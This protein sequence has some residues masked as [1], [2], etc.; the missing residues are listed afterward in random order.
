MCQI[1][2]FLLQISVIVSKESTQ[3]LGMTL[4]SRFNSEEHIK[5]LK[6]KAKR[7]LN[8]LWVVAGKNGE[9]FGK[10]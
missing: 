8:T 6:T 10:P 2:Y 5:K 1:Y 9:E 7:T 4:N 3:F